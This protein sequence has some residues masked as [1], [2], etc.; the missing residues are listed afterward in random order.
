MPCPGTP[1]PAMI[2]ATWVPWRESLTSLGS[3]PRTT[4]ISRADRQV[5]VLADARVDYPDHHARTVCIAAL[6]PE[7]RPRPR[8]HVDR[9][10]AQR[11]P[12]RADRDV[13]RDAR[14]VAG[15]GMRFDY[16]E[17]RYPD[18]QVGGLASSAARALMGSRQMLINIRLQSYSATIA[19][20]RAREHSAS[21]RWDW[22]GTRDV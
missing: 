19:T 16:L 14:P 22:P 12:H 7:V 13:A 4:F 10:S 3:S 2:P 5:T 15:S 8:A 9:R 21:C 20:R 17:M 11:Q 6:Q 18:R 1:R